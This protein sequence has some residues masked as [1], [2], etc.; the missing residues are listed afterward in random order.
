VFI[1]VPKSA[2]LTPMSKIKE[3]EGDNILITAG[4]LAVI[5][6]EESLNLYSPITKKRKGRSKR[7]VS[8]SLDLTTSSSPRKGKDS[9][10]RNS[11][12]HSHNISPVQ[13][14][15]SFTFF[16]FTFSEEMRNTFLVHHSLMS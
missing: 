2:K 8:H 7:P 15:L 4:D 11:L 6:T 1:D 9:S 5:N 16:N 13:N 12:T 3:D 14:L 10:R